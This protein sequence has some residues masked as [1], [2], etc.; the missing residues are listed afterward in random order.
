[1]ARRLNRKPPTEEERDARRKADRERIEQAA[2]ELLTT[3]G[4]RRW[5]KVR[6]SNGL[7]RY[8]VSNQMLI[9]LDCWSR[10][11][12][13]TYVAGFRAFLDLN[14]CVRKGEKAIRILAP[15]TVKQ[16]D[17]NGEETGEKKVFFRT[18]PVFDVSMTDPLPGKE[19]VPLAPPSQPITGDSHHHLIAPLVAHAA[20]L[21]YTVE[22]RQL[23]DDGPAGWCDAKHKQIVV[24]TG[25]ANRQVRTLTHEIAHGHG[26]G[27]S[28]LGRERCEVLVDCVTYCVLGALGL[29]VSGESI[30]YVA[31][32]G[33]DGALDAIRE[34]AQTIDTIA[35]RIEDALDVRSEQ[36]TDAITP[37]PLAA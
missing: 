5:I 26:L 10:G 27:Y 23:P 28:E 29:D 33:E 13:P 16:R 4:W 19:P 8:S 12:T 36:P 32:W 1:M 6:A 7:S 37:D 2:R 22:F 20:A 24:A 3:E 9:A 17:A 30:P 31:G 21:G 25:P 15:V 18:V 35:R 34:Y 11:I 14:R